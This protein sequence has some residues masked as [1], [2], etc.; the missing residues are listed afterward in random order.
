M[1][2]PAILL[3]VTATAAQAQ[4]FEDAVRANTQLATGLCLQVMIQRAAP[5]QVFSAAGF[6]YRAEDRGVNDHGAALGLDHYFDAPAGTAKAETDDPDGAGLCMVMTP[7]LSE[8]ALAQIVAGELFRL[9][10]GTQARGAAEWSVPTSSGL[11]LIVTTDTIGTNHRYED[12]G[13]VRVSMV[14]PG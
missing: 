8:P 9:H 2:R 14:F 5:R 6:T 7:H 10:P 12:P 13:T 4:T 3:A 1:I 11:Q